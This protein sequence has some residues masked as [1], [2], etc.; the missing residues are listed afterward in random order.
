MTEASFEY[1]GNELELFAT[2]KNWKQYIARLIRP[3]ITGDVLEVGAGIGSNT[4]LFSTPTVKSWILL[5]PDKK[6]CQE[7]EFFIHANSLPAG[8]AVF[9]GYTNELTQKFDTIIYIDVIE[10]IA[11]DKKELT[12]AASLL[13]KGGSLIVLSPAH[14]SLMSKFDKAIG[15]YRRYSKKMLMDISNEQL[16]IEKIFYTDSLGLMASFANKYLLKQAYPTKK[17]VAFWD[18]FI[19]PV[20]RL[21]DKLLFYKAGKTIIAVWTKK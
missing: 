8:Y 3:Y 9:N 13:K 16:I 6:F 7:L 15:H 1:I 19:V 17:Q 18:T 12:T 10:H 14:N 4:L 5:E 11:E 21:L 20:S 2:A